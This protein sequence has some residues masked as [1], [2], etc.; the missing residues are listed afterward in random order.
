MKLKDLKNFFV[1]GCAD[2]KFIIL[3]H[4][5]ENIVSVFS[6]IEIEGFLHPLL[7]ESNVSKITFN[8]DEVYI[9]TDFEL[10]PFC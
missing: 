5:G 9:H 10:L 6:F 1:I 3:D 7:F 4:N 2:I 8:L